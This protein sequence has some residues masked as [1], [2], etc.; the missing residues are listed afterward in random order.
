MNIIAI[1]TIFT[2]RITQHSDFGAWLSVVGMALV[3]RAYFYADFF[4]LKDYRELIVFGI[5]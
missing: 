1:M 2:H 5:S 4:S 3:N